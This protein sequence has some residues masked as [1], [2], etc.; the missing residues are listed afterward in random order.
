MVT[1]VAGLLGR[2]SWNQFPTNPITQGGAA[3]VVL[4]LISIG[5]AINLSSSLEMALE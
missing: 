1:M 2:L 5:G 4:G 3:M